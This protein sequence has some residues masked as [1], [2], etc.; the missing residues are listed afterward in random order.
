MEEG[1]GKKER[2]TRRPAV[3]ETSVVWDKKRQSGKE[4]KAGPV[5]TQKETGNKQRWHALGDGTKYQA[6]KKRNSETNEMHRMRE[7][8]RKIVTRTY[9]EKCIRRKEI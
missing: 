7:E 9:G 8:S 5:M 2:A 1:G 3:K 4:R 6:L